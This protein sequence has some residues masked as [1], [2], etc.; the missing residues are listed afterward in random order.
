[1]R[2]WAGLAMRGLHAAVVRVL[3]EN[4]ACAFYEK[5][6]GELLREG[7]LLIGGN[8]YPERWYGWRNLLDLVS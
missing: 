3:A 6:G 5:V 1:M 4:P 8:L 7:Q 2:K